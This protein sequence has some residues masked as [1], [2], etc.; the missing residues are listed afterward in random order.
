MNK[1]GLV[2][3]VALGLA[4]SMFG[5]PM[6]EAAGTWRNGYYYENNKKASGLKKV[7]KYYYYFKRGK[8]L[9][10][11][12]Y[13][14]GKHKYYFDRN[15]RAITGLRRLNNK[16]YYFS[17]KGVML[18]S[19]WKTVKNK[20]YYFGKYGFAVTGLK[21]IGKNY[22]L[23]KSDGSIYRKT[24]I[25]YY[26]NKKYL[27]ANGRVRLG[28]QNYKGG[29]YYFTTK[30][31]HTGWK[32]IKGVKYYFSK[33][34]GRAYKGRS[35]T[36]NGKKYKFSAGGK[37]IT[38]TTNEKPATPTT[39][40]PETPATEAPT[41][42]APATEAPTTEAPTTEAPTTEKPEKKQ[43]YTYS[44]ERYNP[45]GYGLY[46]KTDCI[47][48]VKTDA[49]E[50]Q[51]YVCGDILVGN[52]N[53][54]DVRREILPNG[55]KLVPIKGKYKDGYLVS[56]TFKN[57][58]HQKIWI[59]EPDPN[60]RQ[61]ID[62]ITCKETFY[63][64]V[65]DYDVYEGAYLRNIIN[66][67]TN[68]SM[69]ALEKAK[70]VQ[71]YIAF[72]FNYSDMNANLGRTTHSIKEQGARFEVKK[73]K[74]TDSTALM[75]KVADILGLKWRNLNAETAPWRDAPPTH[76]WTSVFYDG[77]WYDV[78]A[79]PNTALAKQIDPNNIEYVN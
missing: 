70:A 18:R 73:I 59:E 51:F 16:L 25:F 55:N 8:S 79:C 20:K 11:K 53:Y 23:F 42:E 38:A 36:I 68:D 26:K 12:W 61:Y 35:Y 34:T 24:G 50:D 52:M 40:K 1:K 49:P 10:S 3:A 7:G 71:E 37:L 21:K 47:L 64:D 19:S 43:K 76:V 39:E 75:D 66:K 28:L 65:L 32:T 33:K 17:S 77:K 5:A 6:A 27:L 2:K 22:Y 72:N 56:I 14:V 31:M 44:I 74:C 62:F 60:G 41:T 63:F 29:I 48:Y 15:G 30:G 13:T 46:N 78:D 9:K 57:P 67:V 58:G 69:S 54:Y 45:N 4:I